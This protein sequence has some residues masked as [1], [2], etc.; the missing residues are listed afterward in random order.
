MR[1]LLILFLIFFSLKANDIYT[2]G[3]G[4][5][6]NSLPVYVGAYFSVD[7]QDT[8]SS[9]IYRIDDLALL[10]Y[11]NNDKLSY[12]AEVEYKELYTKTYTAS[13]TLSTQNNHIYIERLYLEYNY[14][15]N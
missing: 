1:N 11:G 2:L 6:M 3:E 8:E 7:Y 5:Q 13:S 14:N 12:M 9:Q 15:E 4:V 10:V